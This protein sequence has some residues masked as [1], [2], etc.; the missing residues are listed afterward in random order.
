MRGLQYITAFFIMGALLGCGGHTP[1]TK[2]PPP[3]A[4]GSCP[5]DSGITAEQAVEIAREA[6]IVSAF[7]ESYG[8]CEGC[9]IE[10]EPGDPPR[11]GCV[12]YRARVVC[13]EGD[14]RCRWLVEFWVGEVCSFRYGESQIPMAVEVDCTTSEVLSTSPELPYVT[15]T[16]YCEAD[17]DCL[18]LLGS[19]VPFIGCSNIVHG[20]HHFAGT[21]ECDTCACVDLACREE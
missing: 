1:L 7:L 18:C 2:D 16:T 21:Y 19:G 5:G 3:N 10:D 9:S 4:D 14:T 12:N 15:E 13:D 6:D 17:S 8:S 11:I 20:P